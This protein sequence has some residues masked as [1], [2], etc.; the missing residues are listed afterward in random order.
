GAEAAGIDRL[1]ELVAAADVVV[2]ATSSSGHLITAADVDGDRRRVLID[3]AVPRDIDPAVAGLPGQTLVDVDGLEQTVRRNIRLREGE[4]ERGREVVA[5]HAVAFRVWLCGLEAVPAITSLRGLAEQIRTTELD[6]ARGKWEGMTDHD[7]E[8][9]DRLT[10]G[11]L[12]KLLHR[13]TVRLKELAAEDG[14]EAYAD[15]VSDLFGLDAG[16]PP[17]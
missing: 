11:M 17:R 15:A 9:L 5:E 3:L 14:C 4:A 7:L 8:R 16:P 1:A 2:S 13:P 12:Q 10:R 6:R